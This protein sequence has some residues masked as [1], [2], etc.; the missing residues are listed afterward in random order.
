MLDIK[1]CKYEAKKLLKRYPD[2]ES[3]K[4]LADFPLTEEE[5]KNKIREIED[6]SLFKIQKIIKYK[7]KKD[8]QILD[9]DEET[10]KLNN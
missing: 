1:E 3:L 6:S 8:T 9:L 5:T 7:K 10:R 2:S 4:I